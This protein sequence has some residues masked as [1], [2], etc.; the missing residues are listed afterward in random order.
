MKLLSLTTTEPKQESI[1][2]LGKELSYTFQFETASFE[3]GAQITAFTYLSEGTDRPVLFITNGGPGSSSIWLHLGLFGPRRIHLEN[4]IRPQTIP[5]YALEDNPHCLLDICDLVLIDPPGTGFS[6]APDEEH[7]A[8]FYS[9]DGDALA[10]SL[11]METWTQAHDRTNVP[12]YFIGESYGTL[13]APALADALMGGP[14]SGHQRQVSI[15]LAGI[16]CLGTSFCTTA[17]LLAKPPVEESVMNLPSCAATTAYY[18]PE[19]FSSP[20]AAA[21]EAW[22]VAPAYLGMLFEGRNADSEAQRR[23]AEQ[24]ER[25]TNIPS[26]VLLS[27]Q[28]TY[29]LDQYRNTIQPGKSAGAYDS[30]YLMDGPGVPGSTPFPGMMDIVSEDPAMGRYTPAFVGGMHLLRRELGLDTASVYRA[31][32]FAVNSRW[33]W[34]CNRSPLGSLENAMRRN[35]SMRLFFGTGLYDLVTVAGNVRYT[36]AHSTLPSD[37]VTA[38]EYESGHMPY[39]GEASA[40][41]LE[42]D[43]RAFLLPFPK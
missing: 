16:V 8:R 43:L 42:E 6:A 19:R 3:G 34:Q 15:S 20:A 31:I 41:K 27:Q 38:L 4:P 25:L 26:S 37:R 28:L 17:N 23:M 7:A 36:L 10:V 2:L 39:L 24:L 35:P 5:P 22:D 29:T 11:F 32:D 12:L 40:A 30:R 14:F 33:D 13:R 1:T 21:Q 18:Y 9:V